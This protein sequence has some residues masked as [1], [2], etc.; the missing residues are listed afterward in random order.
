MIPGGDEP[1][2]SAI[3]WAEDT[4]IGLGDDEEVR[5]MSRGDSQVVALH[6]AVVI[7]LGPGPGAR[8]PTDATLEIG[9][10]ANLAI[11]DADP[12]RLPPNG[13]G[14]LTARALVRDGHVV[15]GSLPG[16]IRLAG[17]DH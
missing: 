14:R 3:A 1:D 16:G 8:W 12:R 4:V 7:P 15:A 11:L 10:R 13:D 6:G 9:G 2:A 17:H 5:A